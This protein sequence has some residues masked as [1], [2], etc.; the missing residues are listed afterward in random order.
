[1]EQERERIIIPDEN[2][3]EHIFEELFKF[4]VD[5]TEKSYI[6]LIPV[7]EE[8][9]EDDEGVEVLAFRYEEEDGNSELTLHTIET[10][11]EWDMVEEM[12]NTFEEEEDGEEDDEDEEDKEEK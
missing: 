9:D 5:E 2:G 3:D 7:E 12:L 1:M 8:E 10:D 4:D 11:E 6:L